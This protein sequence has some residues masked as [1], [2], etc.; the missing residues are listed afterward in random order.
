[1][2]EEFLSSFAL[3]DADHR[4][5]EWNEDFAREYQPV[6]VIL[7]KGMSYKE[8]LDAA[9]VKLTSEQIFAG[10]PAVRDP[11]Q[12]L[13][14]RLAGFGQERT[15]EYR[16]GVGRIIRIEERRSLSGGILRYAHDVTDVRDAGSALLRASREQLD[17]GASDLTIAQVEMRRSPDGI[18]DIPRIPES[19]R[20]LLEFTP[21]MVGKDP[22][23]VYTRMI[24]GAEPLNFRAQL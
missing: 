12:E 7:K 10:H 14:E 2:S 20:R 8:M 11:R 1:M 6:G 21:D 23:I 16:N 18:Y 15:S 17:A 13:Q 19:V 4:L 24:G 3:F 5:V 22:M 9:A